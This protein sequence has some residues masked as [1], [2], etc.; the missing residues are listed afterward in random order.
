MFYLRKPP[1]RT[2]LAIP[3][4]IQTNRTFWF[5]KSTGI[6]TTQWDDSSGLNNHLIMT[7][8]PTVNGDGSMGFDGVNDRGTAAFTFEQPCT[9][10]LRTRITTFLAGGVMMDANQFGNRQFA[11]GASTPNVEMIGQFTLGPYSGMTIGVYAS[12]CLMFNGA[13]SIF[14]I[15]GTENSGDSGTT[16]GTGLCFGSDRSSTAFSNFD[17]MESIGYTGIHDANQRNSQINYM[18]TL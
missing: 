17:L 9:I 13:S 11:M 3:G 8:T 4:P 12:I 6:S 1:A 7:G 16:S 18:N 15:N 10:Y 2:S 14:R 5:R